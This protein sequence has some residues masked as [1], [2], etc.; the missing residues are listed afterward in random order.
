VLLAGSGSEVETQLRRRLHPG[1]GPQ[2]LPVERQR[3]KRL[4]EEQ[5]TR[6]FMSQFA[7]AHCDYEGYT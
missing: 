2:S 5:G 3:I 4:R 1:H 6:T 7:A